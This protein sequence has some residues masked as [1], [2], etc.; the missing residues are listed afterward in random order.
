M[1][2]FKHKWKRLRVHGGLN[3]R[4]CRVVCIDLEGY[5]F[6]S[7]MMHDVLFFITLVWIEEITPK[8]WVWTHNLLDQERHTWILGIEYCHHSCWFYTSIQTKA[9]QNKT[10]QKWNITSCLTRESNTQPSSLKQTTLHARPLSPT[11]LRKIL[12][13]TISKRR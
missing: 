1:S 2:S 8:D 11:N 7:R 9:M 4:V 10:Y 12:L 5:W 13:V 6:D 3:C